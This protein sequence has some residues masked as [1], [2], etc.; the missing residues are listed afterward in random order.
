MIFWL[1]LLVPN[2]QRSVWDCSVHS[3]SC[4]WLN[5]SPCVSRVL[6]YPKQCLQHLTTFFMSTWLQKYAKYI[7]FHDAHGQAGDIWK[8]FWNMIITTY[9]SI[10]PCMRHPSFP[11]RKASKPTFVCFQLEQI[12]FW[13]LELIKSSQFLHAQ[14]KLFF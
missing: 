12:W 6:K 10:W 5:I 3:C 7:F 14:K 1:S 2:F 4:P 11:T 13:G 8:Y 9:L